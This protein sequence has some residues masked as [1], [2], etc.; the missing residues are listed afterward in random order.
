MILA[1]TAGIALLSVALI[2]TGLN[3]D[4]SK[5]ISGLLLML[6][7][8]VSAY[9][10]FDHYEQ[11]RQ[12]EFVCDRAHGVLLK[13]V[14]GEKICADRDTIHVLERDNKHFDSGGYND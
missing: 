6:L 4:W 13:T 2:F 7:L 14:N 3:N 8:L 5:W 10:Y 1:L 12:N 9:L 11:S